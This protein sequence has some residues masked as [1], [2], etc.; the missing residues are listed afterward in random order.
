GMVA[1]E[2]YLYFVVYP[3]IEARRWSYATQEGLQVAALGREGPVYAIEMFETHVNSGWVHFLAQQTSIGQVPNPGAQ[4]PFLSTQT[5]AGSETVP[6]PA[7]GKGMSVMIYPDPNQTPY[8]GLLAALYPG[9][10][11]QPEVDGRRAYVVPG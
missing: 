1:Y 5:A 7:M 2:S 9:G 6:V 8:V 11:L 4:L 3:P 10:A